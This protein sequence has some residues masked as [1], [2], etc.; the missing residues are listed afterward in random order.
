MLTET[1]P[2]LTVGVAP[3]RKERLYNTHITLTTTTNLITALQVN[4][5]MPT[6]QHLFHCF[7]KVFGNEQTVKQV[8]TY[9]C[10]GI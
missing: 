6:F 1:V 7:L 3:V 9:K 4:K 2:A 5:D 8:C 10:T